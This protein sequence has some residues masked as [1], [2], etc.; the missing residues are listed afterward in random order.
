MIRRARMAFTHMPA[1]ARVR[2]ADAIAPTLAGAA[3]STSA[4]LIHPAAG[5]AVVGVSVLLWEWAV[6][7]TP[8]T[9]PAGER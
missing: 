1:R 2:I 7:P 6:F 3:F 8:T 9:A 4:F 5:Y